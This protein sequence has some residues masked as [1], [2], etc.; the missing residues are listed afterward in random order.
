MSEKTLEDLILTEDT[1]QE[2]KSKSMLALL[3]LVVILII[4]GAVLAKMIFS[5]SSDTNDTVKVKESSELTLKDSKK[6]SMNTDLA[7]LENEDPDLAPISANTVPSNVDTISIDDS[8]SE[9]KKQDKKDSK[10]D[11][12]VSAKEKAIAKDLEIAP[13]EEVNEDK[14]DEKPKVKKVVE[15][16]EKKPKVIHHKEPKK[17]IYGGRGNVYIQVGSFAKGPEQSFINKIRRAGFKYRIRTIGG[18]RKVYVGPFEN[19]SQAREV[20]G[21]VKSKIASQAFIK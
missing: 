17:H 14:K 8:K 1:P 2:G 11:K 5:D 6:P 16:R 18:L 10:E 4:V 21:I 19:R 15:H 13:I 3:A 12:K 7:P 9:S 20:L